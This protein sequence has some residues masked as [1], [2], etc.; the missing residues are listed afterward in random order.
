LDADAEDLKEE[1]QER[2]EHGL[3]IEAIL[4][5]E[6]QYAKEITLSKIFITDESHG[7]MVSLARI[8]T[9]VRNHYRKKSIPDH[10]KVDHF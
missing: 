5:L 3:K 6:D 7:L 1:M 4:N 10:I 8:L 9:S 2:L